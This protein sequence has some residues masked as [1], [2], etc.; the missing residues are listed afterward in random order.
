VSA[1][2]TR[3]P[4]AAEARRDRR[5]QVPRSHDLAAGSVLLGLFAVAAALSWRKWG[6]PEIDA[7]SEL[8]TADLVSHGAVPY[9]DVRYFYGPLGL[10]GLAGAFRVFGSSFTTAYAFGLFQAAAILGVFYA[11]ARQWLPALSAALS[12]AVLLAIGFS[13]TAFNFVLPHTNSATFGVLFLLAMLLAMA[14]GRMSVAGVCLG[15]VALTR[16]EFAVV[17]VAS[18]AGYVAGEWRDAGRSAALAAGRSL[19]LPAGAVAGA[20]YSA[21]AAEAGAGRLLTENLW[22]VDFIRIAGFKT[23]EDWMPLSLAG[24]A[25]LVMRALVYGGLLAAAVAS[26]VRVRT[27][28]RPSAGLPLAVVAV[29]LAATDLL[30]RSTGVLDAQR[31]AIEDDARHLVLGMSWLPALGLAAA[32][33]MAVRFTRRAQ[34]PLSGRWALDLALTVAAAALGLRA[35]NAFTG[36][37]SY[38]PYYAAPLVLLLG[39]LHQRIAD[40]YPAARPVALGALAVVALGLA[41]YAF[42]GL[43]ADQTTAVS[44]VRGTY[45]TT[46]AAAPAM[47]GTLAAIRRDSRPD[48]RILA[49]PADGGVYFMADRR[50]ALYELMLLPGLLDSRADER[51]A[52]DTLRAEHVRVAAIASRDFSAWGWRAFGRDYNR[53]LGAYLRRHAVRRSVSGRGG[54]Q[55]GTNASTRIAVLD[56]ENSSTAG[57]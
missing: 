8:T 26:A 10:Y 50:P 5:Q 33:W 45:V 25:G 53:V 43:Y 48:E 35:Y 41:G 12:T 55:A 39:L 30:L 9:A 52:V 54:P 51:H 29:A 28:A 40:R 57:R 24:G 46:A 17:A 14:R 31:S 21:F 23:Q 11:L 44:T 47:R 20:V 27:R 3:R 18:A 36:E 6:V 34:S 37:A 16:P 4:A 13:G 22:P 56:M 2:L 42:A 15:L 7:G 1:T 32:A 38:A 19:A 49:A